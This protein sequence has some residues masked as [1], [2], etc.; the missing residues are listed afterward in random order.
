M[1][2]GYT[3]HEYR[4]RC[5]QDTQW[6]S[7]VPVPLVSV[8]VQAEQPEEDAEDGMRGGCERRV[9]EEGIRGGCERRVLEEGMRGGYERRV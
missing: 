1:P 3:V 8:G 4:T 5:L 2:A 6:M 7:K 9:L